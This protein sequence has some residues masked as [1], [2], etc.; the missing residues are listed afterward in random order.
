MITD[1]WVNTPSDARTAV[2]A[3]HYRALFNGVYDLNRL[4]TEAAQAKSEVPEERSGDPARR[5]QRLRAYEVAVLR[6]HNAAMLLHE[7]T[8]LVYL[9]VMQTLGV[10][11]TEDRLDLRISAALGRLGTTLLGSLTTLNNVTTAIELFHLACE[12]SLKAERVRSAAG[13]NFYGVKAATE[14]AK[15]MHVYQTKMVAQVPVPVSDMEPGGAGATLLQANGEC[16]AF[17]RDYDNLGASAC[18]HDPRNKSDISASPLLPSGKVFRV[19]PIDTGLAQFEL[20]LYFEYEAAY[21]HEGNLCLTETV[22]L[23]K[24]PARFYIDSQKPLGDEPRAT[25]GIGQMQ[26]PDGTTL[27]IFGDKKRGQEKR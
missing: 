23:A 17:E 11:T 3:T 4:L 6:V 22:G 18:I 12:L 15:R 25:M 7:P 20:D 5:N 16:V 2:L 10:K 8:A 1:N 26:A 9:A 19:F 21:V 13:T 27:Y 14:S 24:Q